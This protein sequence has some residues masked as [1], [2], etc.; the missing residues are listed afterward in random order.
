[1]KGASI[2]MLC[3]TGA[4]ASLA[5]FSRHYRDN[6]PQFVGLSLLVLWCAGEV[7]AVL[8][9]AP[10]APRALLLYIS[11]AAFAGGTARKVLHHKPR[12]PEVTRTYNGELA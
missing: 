12:D 10:V 2:V 3:L 11:L 4:F 1:M 8:Q 7:S 9:G 6:W 5:V